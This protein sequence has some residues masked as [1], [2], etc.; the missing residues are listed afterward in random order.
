VDLILTQLSPL[1]SDLVFNNNLDK[2]IAVRKLI[3][4]HGYSNLYDRLKFDGVSI[5]DI[6]FSN[7]V[8]NGVFEQVKKHFEYVRCYPDPNIIPFSV[9]F[10]NL[11]TLKVIESA[12]ALSFA[13]F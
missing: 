1:L 9:N 5:R 2:N 4:N 7:T 8:V 10:P 11:L 12:Y 3:M 6:K 13:K